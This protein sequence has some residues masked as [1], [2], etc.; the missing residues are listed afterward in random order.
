MKS[1]KDLEYSDRKF[2]DDAP[3]LWHWHLNASL[4]I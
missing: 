3:Q 2:G 4:T 1:Q